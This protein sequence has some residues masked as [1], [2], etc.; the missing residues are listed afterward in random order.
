MTRKSFDQPLNEV[1]LKDAQPSFDA[2]MEDPEFRH[3]YEEESLKIQV[4]EAIRHRRKAMKLTQAKLA[5][6]VKTN[7]TVISRV[8]Q[9]DVSIGV[10]LLQRIAQA[11]GANV[12]LTLR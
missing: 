5:E 6:R 10:D 4:A 2:W 12:T 1:Y 9:G 8:E 11:L 3:A 7:Q